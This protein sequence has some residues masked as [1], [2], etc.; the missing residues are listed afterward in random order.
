MEL[1]NYDSQLSYTQVKEQSRKMAYLSGALAPESDAT[2][3]AY[4]SPEV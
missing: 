4:I 1:T 2:D 3:L